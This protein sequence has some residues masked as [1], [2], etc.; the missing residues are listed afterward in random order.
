[1]S[2]RG[3]DFLEDWL[4]GQLA[5]VPVGDKALLR[6]LAHQLKVDAAAAGFTLDDLELEVSQVEP[7]IRCDIEVPKVGETPP[8][9]FSLGNSDYFLECIFQR[10]FGET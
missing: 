10:I 1:M 7:L 5:P 9:L 6:M 8:F 3:V 2:A 4:A